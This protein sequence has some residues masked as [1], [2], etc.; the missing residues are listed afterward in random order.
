MTKV[1][2]MLLNNTGFNLQPIR[3]RTGELAKP[4]KF[5]Q[6]IF[7][8]GTISRLDDKIMEKIIKCRSTLRLSWN[9]SR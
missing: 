9:S 8:E 3:Q 6:K 2:Q 5:L 7:V 4:T 1:I